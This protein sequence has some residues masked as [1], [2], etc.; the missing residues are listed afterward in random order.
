MTRLWFVATF[1]VESPA[2]Y[3]NP[4]FS[5]LVSTK[6]R[7]NHIMD[8]SPSHPT[9]SSKLVHLNPFPF[10]ASNA[11]GSLSSFFVIHVSGQIAVRRRR[12]S[13]KKGFI[14]S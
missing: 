12:R 14:L 2:V 6:N 1:L 11:S 9:L 8:Y 7:I 13:K 10:S 4:T 3:L 5:A